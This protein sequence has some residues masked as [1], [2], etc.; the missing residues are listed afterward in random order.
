MPEF[1]TG[2]PLHP[3]V[4]HAVVVMI[5]L[6][7]LGAIVIAVWPS[8]RHRFGWLVVG[9]AAIGTALVPVATD[10]GEK[11]ERRLGENPMINQHQDLGDDLLWFMLPLLA[12]VLGLMVLHTMRQ[13]QLAATAGEGPGTTTAPPRAAAPTA[14]VM[15]VVAVL[16]VGFAVAAG[17]HAFRTGESGARAVWDFVED[18]PPP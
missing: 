2:L 6:A 13:R 18:Q 16:T 4:V 11:L 10:S 7:V 1:I 8:A 15:I 9:A 5:P 17:I 3:L 14:V 12:A